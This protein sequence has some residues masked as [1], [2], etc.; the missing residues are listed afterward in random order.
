MNHHR[1]FGDAQF[2]GDFRVAQSLEL[3]QDEDLPA[4][5]WQFQQSGVQCQR[6]LAGDHQCVRKRLRIGATVINEGVRVYYRRCAPFNAMNVDGDRLGSAL[7]IALEV[8][9]IIARRMNASWTASAALWA[10]IPLPTS[11]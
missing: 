9:D 5:R 1:I 11:C 3:M 7:N 6:I 8:P 10:D 4:S 2:V